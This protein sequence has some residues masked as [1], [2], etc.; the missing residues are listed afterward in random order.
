MISPLADDHSM[1]MTTL[2]SRAWGEEPATHQGEG[3]Y[4]ANIEQEACECIG[5]EIVLLK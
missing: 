4:K 2:T 5:S 3:L 1:H